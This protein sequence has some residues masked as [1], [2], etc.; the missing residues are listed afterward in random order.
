VLNQEIGWEVRIQNDF[1]N[2][3]LCQLSHKS[4]SQL[5]HILVV[6]CRWVSVRVIRCWSGSNSRKCQ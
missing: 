1:L 4:V 2:F 5:M 6:H 3:F